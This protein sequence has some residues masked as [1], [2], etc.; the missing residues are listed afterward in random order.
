ML[1]YRSPRCQQ[2]PPVLAAAL[3]TAQSRGQVVPSTTGLSQN[4]GWAVR[5]AQF[6]NASV[7]LGFVTLTWEHW[8]VRITEPGTEYWC[9][10][11]TTPD[12]QLLI[13]NWVEGLSYVLQSNILSQ[14]FKPKKEDISEDEES[15][16]SDWVKY[17]VKLSVRI[18]HPS[19]TIVLAKHGTFICLE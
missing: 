10:Y 17:T 7:T 1:K 19:R 15:C 3:S 4:L 16:T 6:Q 14:N 9:F 13:K 5:C 12:T 18:H 11:L 8:A 2:L